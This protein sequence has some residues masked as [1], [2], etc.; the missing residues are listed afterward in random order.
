MN[1]IRWKSPPM[2]CGERLDRHRLRQTRHPLD[3]Q[4]PAGEQRDEHP[5]DEHVLPDD[6]PLHLVERLLE[7]V[8]TSRSSPSMPSSWSSRVVFAYA[9]WSS[10]VP[11]TS[12]VSA[13]WA[14]RAPAA[15]AIGTA[16]PMPTKRLWSVGLASP[17]TMP[18]TWPALLSSGPPELPG[19]TA[20][21]IW[22]RCSS[23]RLPVDAHRP[24]ERRDDPGRE[25]VDEP[26]R[27]AD[28]EDRR[29]DLPPRRRAR[30]AR[31]SPAASAG[32]SVAMSLSGLRLAILAGGS[33]RRRR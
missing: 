12:A 17:V 33:C 19:L 5:L 4:V 27:V 32:V 24:F 8:P 13:R 30:P 22:M 7:R 6:R 20:A 1:W 18:T 26:E 3:E 29:P 9:V 25:R 14:A 28:G 2:A 31:R 23:L 10:C 11:V 16:K 15:V 21:S